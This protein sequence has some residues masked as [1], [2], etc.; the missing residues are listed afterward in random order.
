MEEIDFVGFRTE[1]SWQLVSQLINH[2][3]ADSLDGVRSLFRDGLDMV[4][5]CQRAVTTIQETFRTLGIMQEYQAHNIENHPSISGE[6]TQFFLI[7]NWGGN[8]AGDESTGS[9]ND[10]TAKLADVQNIALGAKTASST[11][12]FLVSLYSHLFSILQ[13]LLPNILLSTPLTLPSPMLPS[14]FF[15]Q[16]LL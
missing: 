13:S 11:A 5:E 4:D 1:A 10:L 3:F 14:Y 9:I 16:F 8:K 6:Y 7:A 15:H 12:L 2:I